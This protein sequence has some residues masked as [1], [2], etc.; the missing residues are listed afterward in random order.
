MN[1]ATILLLPQQTLKASPYGSSCR[2]IALYDLYILPPHERIRA[3]AGVQQFTYFF[4]IF[5]ILNT[6][7]KLTQ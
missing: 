3:A 4:Y 7:L 5:C 6:L 2:M 1:Y